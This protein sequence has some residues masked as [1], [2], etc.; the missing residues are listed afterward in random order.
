MILRPESGHLLR[1]FYAEAK[2]ATFTGATRAFASATSVGVT[3]V[4][5]R[6]RSDAVNDQ[7]QGIIAGFAVITDLLSLPETKS[8]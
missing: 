8:S 1:T 5:T 2:N 4:N 7:T 3:K 6:T